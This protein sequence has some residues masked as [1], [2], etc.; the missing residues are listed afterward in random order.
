MSRKLLMW[1]TPWSTPR[2]RWS[3]RR[4]TW[5]ASSTWWRRGRWRCPGRASSS[6]SCPPGSCL[7][8]WPSSTTARELP[9]SKVSCL[10]SLFTVYCLLLT[11]QQRI[12][13]TNRSLRLAFCRPKLLQ[14]LSPCV[15]SVPLPPATADHLPPASWFPSPRTHTER[16]S[17]AV[18]DDRKLSVGFCF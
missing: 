15:L 3:S 13:I 14:I 4:A 6:P 1:C 5:A 16:E 11:V 17:V 7:G 8:S 9:Q 18:L 12:W 10:N 2:D